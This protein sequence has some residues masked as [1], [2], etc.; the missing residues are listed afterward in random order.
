MKIHTSRVWL[1]RSCIVS[2]LAGA[3]VLGGCGSLSE[4]ECH[5]ADWHM[6]GY[7]DG[8]AGRPAA[9]LG[10]HR[11]ACSDYGITPDLQAYRRGRDEG[12]REYCQPRRAYQLGRNGSGYPHACPAELEDALRTAYRDGRKLYE[13]ESEINGMQR[14][15]QRKENELQH[16]EKTQISHQTEIIGPNTSGAR[17]VQLLAETW[18]LVKRKDAV[19]DEIYELESKIDSKRESLG[20]MQSA[21]RY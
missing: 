10:E 1:Y 5:S 20:E 19:E 3:M 12:L 2:A 13:V 7:E 17:R 9:R 8:A 14:S 11:E 4:K 6:I 18:D 21:T 15:L 16:I